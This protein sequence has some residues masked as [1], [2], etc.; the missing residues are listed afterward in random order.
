MEYFS[1][2]RYM[3]LHQRVEYLEE[4]LDRQQLVKRRLTN[5]TLR[6]RVGE[7]LENDEEE[8][9]QEAIQRYKS[10]FSDDEEDDPEADI[11]KL[12]LD[13]HTS[14]KSFSKRESTMGKESPRK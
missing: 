10:N 11:E 1:F 14:Y 12:K 2:G 4:E 13:K 8:N 9:M 7:L 5:T 3:E 6:R